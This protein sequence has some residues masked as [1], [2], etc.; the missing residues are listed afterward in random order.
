MRKI[1]KYKSNLIK[2]KLKYNN[3]KLLGNKNSKN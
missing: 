3:Y 1:Y 2:K